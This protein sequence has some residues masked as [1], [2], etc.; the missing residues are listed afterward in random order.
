MPT[1]QHQTFSRPESSL[2]NK[3]WE[4]YR[5]YVTSTRQAFRA[6][7]A[8]LP[9]GKCR[10]DFL[11]VNTVMSPQEFAECLDSMAGDPE[12][13][14]RVEKAFKIRSSHSLAKRSRSVA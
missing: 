10:A 12:R 7:L 1:Q 5:R 11:K 13:R 8:L 6:M 4:L 14:R 3:D 2:N 9:R